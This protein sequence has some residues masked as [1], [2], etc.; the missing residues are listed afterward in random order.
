MLQKRKSGRAHT[1]DLN[2]MAFTA[3]MAVYTKYPKAEMEKVDVFRIAV[4]S[5]DIPQEWIDN[6]HSM[7][8]YTAFSS[9]CRK[10]R[11]KDDE[12]NMVPRLITYRKWYHMDGRE[13]PKWMM[14]PIEKCGFH[15]MHEYATRQ[16]ISIKADQTRLRLTLRYWNRYVRPEGE[17]RV[18]VRF[19]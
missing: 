9:L 12:G 1:S 7:A 19:D 4:D 10:T 3:F 5:G 18:V 16:K 8:L 2:R 17:K 11:F 15:E 13:I 14:M 6:V